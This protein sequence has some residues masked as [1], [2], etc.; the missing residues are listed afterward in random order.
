MSWL[1]LEPGLHGEQRELGDVHA[2]L[3]VDQH[4]ESLVPA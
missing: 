1:R 3:G 2:G 4:C